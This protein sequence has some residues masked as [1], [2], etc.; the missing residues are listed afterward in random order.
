MAMRTPTSLPVLA[1]LFL[2]TALHAES[3]GSSGGPVKSAD[4]SSAGTCR[5]TGFATP[6]LGVP[7]VD[8]NGQAVARFGGV[9]VP[10]TLSELPEQASGRFRVTTGASGRL[11]IDGYVDV[12][13][14]PLFLKSEVPVVAGQV[15]IA[16]G[17]RVEFAGRIGS[18]LRIKLTLKTPLADTFEATV[19]CDAISL[20]PPKA[21][22]SHIPGH[23]RA[24]YMK[25]PSVSLFDVPGAQAK[26][27]ASL[28][29]A[30]DTRG[31]LFFGD[32]RAGDYIHV[33]YRQDVR[34]EGWISVKDL[35]LLP[36]GEL[37]DQ[38]SLKPSSSQA[39][40][41]NVA[42][43]AKLYRSTSE[44]ALHGKA[45]PKLSPIGVVPKDTEL[46]VLDVV[47]G[48][49]NVLPKQ[50]D[51]V[52]LDERRFWVRASELGI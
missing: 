18:E 15:F 1:A 9:P 20:E 6:E 43:D 7:I 50:L 33:L 13:S 8:K 28:H 49:A 46:Y 30:P 51:V 34:I 44:I 5:L 11:S 17:A 45:D 14:V 22:P 41:L 24:Y 4:S 23:A 26:S 35:E 3:K 42:A 29:L 48:W 21:E 32:R 52:P 31:V 16:K 2:S 25:S 37:V 10:V 40:R 12:K 27:V 39:S 47:V 36:K 19:P 38:K